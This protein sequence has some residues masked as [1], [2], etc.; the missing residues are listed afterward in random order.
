MRIWVLGP[1][2]FLNSQIS[3][4]PTIPTKPNK[5]VRLVGWFVPNPN[6]KLPWFTHLDHPIIPSSLSPFVIVGTSRSSYVQ[7]YLCNMWQIAHRF[8]LLHILHL[9]SYCFSSPPSQYLSWTNFVIFWDN[10]FGGRFGWMGF[11]LIYS[12]VFL[13]NNLLLCIR[14]SS[15]LLVLRT[16]G[17]IAQVR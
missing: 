10:F 8:V 2:F 12:S 13:G 4:G 14:V 7:N 15:Q 1:S 6:L 16:W 9:F 11:L 5:I 17:Y 3:I